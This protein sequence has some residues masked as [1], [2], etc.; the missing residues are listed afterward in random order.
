MNTQQTP[1]ILLVEDNPGDARYIRE[2]L[3]ETVSFEARTVESGV[4]EEQV[5]ETTNPDSPLTHET[6]LEDAVQRLDEKYADIVLL[7]LGLPDSTGLDTLRSLNDHDATVPIVVLTGLQDHEV[8]VEALRNGAEE[9]LVKDEINSGLL[10]RSIHHAIERHAHRQEQQRYEI[11][12]EEAADVNAIISTDFTFEYITP[13]VE[14]VLGYEPG[15]L[16]GEDVTDYIHPEDR[17]VVS[18]EFERLIGDPD[19]RATSDLRFRHADGSWVVLDARGRNL[20][21]EPAIGG[22]VVYTRDVTEQRAYERRL[23]TQRERLAALNQLNGVVHGLTGAVIDQS[24]R[25]EIEQIAC[26]RLAASD[27]YEFAWVA[28]PDTEKQ[29]LSVRAEAGAADYLE[30]VS[31]SI[32]PNDPEGE[33]PTGRAL[34]TGETH[35]V[36]DIHS[37]P[38]YEPWRDAAQAHDFA[39]S[40]AIPIRHEGTTYGT[41]NVYAS[42][43]G[44]FQEQE[45][46]VID[47]LGRLL[48]HAIAATER[49]RALMSE[50]VVELEFRIPNATE[51]LG[52]AAVPDGPVRF[53]RTIP[54]KDEAFLV[55]GTVSSD[56]VPSVEQMVDAVSAW[57]SIDIVEETGGTAWFELRLTD[58]PIMSDVASFG[59]SIEQVVI[60]SN[61]LDMTVH[62]PQDIEVRQVVDTFRSEYPDVEPLARR[63]LMN[64]DRHTEHSAAAWTDELTERQRTVVETA[65]FSGFFEWPRAT[66]GEEVAEKLDISGPTFSQHL[67]TAEEKLFGELVG[68]GQAG[69]DGGRRRERDEHS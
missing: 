22:L 50:S 16:I 30:N 53:H 62:L 10:G 44:A 36:S 56:G 59:G 35:T 29:S 66:S 19:Y 23:E 4:F 21:E 14:H 55:Y 37:N 58:E 18:G 27:S 43:S 57:E 51:L 68:G 64:P 8:G 12:T 49:K 25:D 47:H 63:Q 54:L 61:E 28:E 39:A 48:G 45:R 5:T 7:D 38:Q 9:F 20:L 11:L 31:I 15:E 46:T 2:L 52:H 17:S 69:T 42:R 1:N 40:A 3:R 33:G 67:R 65:Y 32:D 60:E 34:R 26:D 24:T 6:T 13:S 41:L